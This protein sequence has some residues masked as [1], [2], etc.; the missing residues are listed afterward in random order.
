MGELTWG[1][2]VGAAFRDVVL[3]MSPVEP[4]TAL[5]AVGEEPTEGLVVVVEDAGAR[6]LLVCELRAEELL[7]PLRPREAC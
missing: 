2:E 6:E 1:P 5:E 7:R 4:G 3:I